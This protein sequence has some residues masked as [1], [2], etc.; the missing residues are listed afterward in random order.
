M[1]PRASVRVKEGGVQNH[2]RTIFYMKI[3][4]TSRKPFRSERVRRSHGADLDFIALFLAQSTLA[5]HQNTSADVRLL[6]VVNVL[7]AST[8][9]L[10]LWFIPGLNV[11]LIKKALKRQYT[12]ERRTNGFSKDLHLILHFIWMRK[13]TCKPKKYYSNG[14]FS[15]WVRERSTCARG[16]TKRT[17]GPKMHCL[18]CI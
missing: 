9:A 18:R 15:G 5:P 7:I 2:F 3:C 8:S 12:A 16:P 10:R 6:N 1:C 13:C 11:F 17:V 14:T 4:L